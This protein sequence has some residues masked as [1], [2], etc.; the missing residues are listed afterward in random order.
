MLEEV[1][2]DRGDNTALHDQ[3]AGQI[4]RAIAD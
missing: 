1:K 4:R 3:V 2:L